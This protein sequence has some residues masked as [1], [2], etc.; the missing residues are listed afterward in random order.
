[1]LRSFGS[2]HLA[3]CHFPLMTPAPDTFAVAPVTAASSAEGKQ[4]GQT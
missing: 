1:M 2:G 3:A 4:T